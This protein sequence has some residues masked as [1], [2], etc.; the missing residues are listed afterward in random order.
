VTSRLED[1]TKVSLFSQCDEIF[2]GQDQVTR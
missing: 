1:C 2:E